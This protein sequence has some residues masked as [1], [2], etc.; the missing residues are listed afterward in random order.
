MSALEL[1]SAVQE[2]LPV[3]VLLVNDSCLTLIKATQQ[4]RYEERYIGV[5]LRNP[6]FEVLARSFGVR[7]WR[8]ETEGGL[9]AA[10]REAL[11]A[12]GGGRV[13]VRPGGAAGGGRAPP[14]RRQVSRR[15]GRPRPEGATP[16]R[17]PP[18]GSASTGSR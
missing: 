15:P 4:R 2:R 1:A 9:E 12:G 10:L 13:G 3:V 16:S 5:D 17:C 11:G 14:A 7:Y 18:P 8:P 6:D